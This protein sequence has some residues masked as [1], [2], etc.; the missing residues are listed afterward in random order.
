MFYYRSNITSSSITIKEVEVE[1][2]DD[3][4]SFRLDFVDGNTLFVNG[5]KGVVEENEADEEEGEDDEDGDGD[6]ENDDDDA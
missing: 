4:L 2:E 1:V 5:I 3:S 6:D